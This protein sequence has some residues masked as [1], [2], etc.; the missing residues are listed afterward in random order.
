MR[1]QAASLGEVSCYVECDI[2]TRNVETKT[3]KPCL[4]EKAVLYFYI[5]EINLVVM[6]TSRLNA[7][8]MNAFKILVTFGLVFKRLDKHTIDNCVTKSG[9]NSFAR[10]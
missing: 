10:D 5:S 3:S 6:C 1:S 7:L 2:F 8:R 4:D 9:P